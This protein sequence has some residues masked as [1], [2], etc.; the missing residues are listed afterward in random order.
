MMKIAVIDIGSNSVRLMLWANGK[1]LYKKIAT[2][3]LG[4]G[5]AQS[6]VLCEESMLR[7]VSAISSFLA[8][9][10]ENGVEA[11][12]AFATAA[13]RCAR[14]GAD[15]CTRVKNSCGVEIDVISGDSEALLGLNGALGTRDGGIVDIGGAST[16]ICFREKGKILFSKSFPVGAVRLF[17]ICRDEKARL[18]ETI[19]GAL[20]GLEGVKKCGSLYAV[21]GTASTLA[22]VKL[23]L[24]KYDP[25]QLNDLSLSAKW[26]E[27]IAEKLLGMTSVAR[28]QIA[29]M[30]A[31]RADII[32]GGAFLL[33][34]I[35]KKLSVTE[36]RFSDSDNLEGYL[37]YRGLI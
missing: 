35:M 26:V 19:D 17:D 21:G 16:E 24:E 34:E 31:G 4:A 20:S 6:G 30:E 3:R 15:F 8:E 29:G 32:A 2:T 7:S 36:V 13:V 12:F 27:G 9:T 14:N 23:G 33:S 5:L 37:V 18:K 1:S 22:S 25:V 28:V 10:E 11:V